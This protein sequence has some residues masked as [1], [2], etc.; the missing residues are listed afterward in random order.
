[1]KIMI[2]EDNPGDIRL[3]YEMLRENSNFIF[4]LEPA[5]KL[6]LGLEILS[7]KTVDLILLDIGLPDS[8]GISSYINVHRQVP[9]IPIIILT[10]L[11]DEDLAMQAVQQGAQDYLN[12][13]E[14]S[15]NL[16]VRTIRY[17]VERN[18]LGMELKS[19]SRD[20]QTKEANFRNVVENNADGIIIVGYD[21]IIRLINPVAERF[22]LEKPGDRLYHIFGFPLSIAESQEINVK[23]KDKESA[24]LEMHIVETFWEGSS[25]YLV[26]LRDITRRKQAE[27]GLRESQQFLKDIINFLPDAT[28]VIDQNGKVISWNY[29]ME[30]MS[31]V[32]AKDMIGK[33]DYE[34]SIPFY[35]FRRPV[36]IDSVL[37]LY[38][39]PEYNPVEDEQGMYYTESFC[40]AVGEKG[41]TAQI[42]ASILYNISGEKIGAIQSVRDITEQKKAEEKIKYLSFFD[43][44]TG[45]YNRAFFEEE[46]KRLDT[47]RQL[48]LSLIIAD[49]NGLKLVNDAFGHY[50]GDGLLKEVASILKSC[51][52]KED[53]V[54]RWGGDEFV[55]LLPLISSQAALSICDRIKSACLNSNS[56]PFQVSVSLGLATKIDP[57][58]NS[59]AILKEA[60][61]KMYRNKL[62]ENKS[63]RSSF[64]TS[65]EETLWARSH[66]TE[67]HCRRM[68]TMVEIFG[69]S[70]GLLGSELDSLILLAALHDIGKIA[71]P[72]S[73]LENPKGLSSQEWEAIKKHPEIGYRIVLSSPE[74]AG[75]AD[76]ILTHHERWDGKGYPLGLKGDNILLMSRIL[77]IVDAYDV[78]LNGRPYKQ[79]VSQDAVLQELRRCAGH[80]FDPTLVSV[81]DELVSRR[82]FH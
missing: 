61:D 70:L 36:M 56:S 73:I 26:C 20:L 59:H 35:G 10:G 18:R 63:T 47:P 30:K 78:M 24:V 8:Q 75:I 13:G 4:Q 15:S 65:L 79:A 37:N 80:Q 53:V 41:I 23:Q 17:A 74:L 60:E 81:F 2:I 69:K 6:S 12:K 77:T 49:V 46:F 40:P 9:D 51:C 21:G 82:K 71:I 5:E 66:E 34:Y 44:L 76:A 42:N 48:P 39:T 16:L 57:E 11:E 33:G 31:G 7:E 45:V 27:A 72:S 19:Y 43:K 67:E 3:I 14:L 22:F 55:I 28:F 50:A 25:A 54:A 68:R 38:G 32:K 58:Q 62:L 64:I 29:A 1:M 52:R